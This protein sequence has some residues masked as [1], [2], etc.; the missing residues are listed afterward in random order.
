MI[1]LIGSD[2]MKS[3]HGLT[4]YEV[5]KILRTGEE[6]KCKFCKEGVFKAVGDYKKTNTFRCSH[7]KKEIIV[8]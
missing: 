8:N 7:C 3:M 1:T 4:G 2:N 5:L 6:M